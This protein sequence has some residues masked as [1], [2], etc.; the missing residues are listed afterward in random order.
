MSDTTD[1][2]IV[3]IDVNDKV[4]TFERE[5]YHA[6]IDEDVPVG[7]SI[8]QVAASVSTNNDVIVLLIT[9]W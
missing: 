9:Y 1:V 3:L 6:K 4:P 2:E 5:Y 7:T 8:L